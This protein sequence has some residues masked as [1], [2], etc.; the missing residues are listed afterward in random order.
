MKPMAKSPRRKSTG[1]RDWYGQGV[2]RH[3]QTH[4]LDY[5]NPH[6]P[7]VHDLLLRA[8]RELQVDW[9]AVLDLAAGSGEVTRGVAAFASNVT[10]IDPF[11]HAGYA[12]ATCRPCRELSFEQIARGALDAE[13]FSVV[14]C[15]FAMHLCP[16]SVLPTL[17][18]ALAR[19]APTLLI[20]TPHKRPAVR[21]EWGWALSHELMDHR[22]RL[23]QYRSTV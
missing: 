2:D 18:L 6:E 10:A 15:S 8:S 22:V 13:R 11:T 9:S 20:L 21:P 4:A 12:R 23:R 3:Y 16:E 1:A 7:I 17:C 14:V 5:R 19:V